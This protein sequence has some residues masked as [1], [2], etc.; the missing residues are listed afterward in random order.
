[1]NNENKLLVNSKTDEVVDAIKNS[2]CTCQ[3]PEKCTCMAVEY[4]YKKQNP[5]ILE[6]DGGVKIGEF[7]EKNRVVLFFRS[8]YVTQ[9]SI[10]LT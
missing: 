5:D 8:E 7:R 4:M 9:E 10:I 6:I 3:S 2:I 1:M